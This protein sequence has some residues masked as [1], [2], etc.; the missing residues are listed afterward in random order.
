MNNIKKELNDFLKEHTSEIFV[1]LIFSSFII[2]FFIYRDCVFTK[3]E[4]KDFLMP[5]VV[6]VGFFLAWLQF[7]FYKHNKKKEA[8]LTYFPRP[9]ELE[10]IENQIDK[11]IQFWS[12]KDPLNTYEVKLMIGETIDNDEYKLIWKKLSNSIKREIIKECREI[13][14]SKDE[15][16]SIEYEE[17]Y[18]DLIDEVYIDTRRKL[19]LYLNQVEGYC[20]ALN[21]GNID[22]KTSYDMF[23][24]K[25]SHKFSNH[26]RKARIYIDMVREQK[27]EPDLYKEFESVLRKWGKL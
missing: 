21:K 4:I 7:L 15:H 6:L 26:F 12:K 23:S 14:A 19:N 11:V 17:N 24:H 1:G 8:A 2:T 13:C 27:N 5:I 9:M 22:S 16:I 18:N 10:K 3:K 20:L 25:F